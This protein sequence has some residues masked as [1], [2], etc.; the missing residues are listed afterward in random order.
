MIDIKLT[1]EGDIEWANGDLHYDESAEQHKRD[2]LMAGKGHFKNFPLIGVDA[3]RY[4]NDIRPD[5]F[6]RAVRREFS[7]DGMTIE[8]ITT[9]EIVANY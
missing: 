3:V 2:I 6:F 8:R 1:Q 4:L 9:T 7:R 5:D